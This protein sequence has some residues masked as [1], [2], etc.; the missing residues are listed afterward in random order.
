MIRPQAVAAPL[1]IL[2]ICAVAGA[3]TPDDYDLLSM[4][5]VNSARTNPLGEDTMQGTSFGET[6]VAPLAYDLLVGQA[7]TLSRV[8]QAVSI[9]VDEHCSVAQSRFF[10]VVDTIAVLIFEDASPDRA[11]AS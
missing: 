3:H 9:R 10:V 1:I 6:A 8:S 11:H 7:A 5:L 2:S 4:R